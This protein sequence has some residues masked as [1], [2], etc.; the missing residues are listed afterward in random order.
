MG[1]KILI[2]QFRVFYDAVTVTIF[3]MFLE[4]LLDYKFT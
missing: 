3:A 4:W 2:E 1:N